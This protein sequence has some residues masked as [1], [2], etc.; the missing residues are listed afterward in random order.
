[1]ENISRRE[2][3][4]YSI[5]GA[6]LMGA[7]TYS[8]KSH[9][10]AFTAAAIATGEKIGWAAKP[11]IDFSVDYI[12]Q[13]LMEY[14]LNVNSH[15]LKALTKATEHVYQF[16]QEL[17]RHDFSRR[18]QTLSAS[19]SYN[20]LSAVALDRGLQFSETIHSLNTNQ[21]LSDG[22]NDLGPIDL[23]ISKFIFD[24]DA[25]ESLLTTQEA[26][27][28]KRFFQRMSVPTT[29]APRT[30]LFAKNKVALEA[31]KLLNHSAI[32]FHMASQF[33]GKH[34]DIAEKIEST[35]LNSEWRDSLNN[36]SADISLLQEVVL[37]KATEVQLEFELLI[38]EQIN[39]VLECLAALDQADK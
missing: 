21:T 14:V 38:H 1:M 37:Q 7:G 22:N 20:N 16:E 4:K 17:D 35:Y 8:S 24:Q 23:T 12:S 28:L 34:I 9:A 32:N 3:F 18:I 36:S 11:F 29:D 5:G 30:K 33:G 6:E 10:F 26:I 15:N 31:R 19:C 25:T 27:E 2:L 13:Y 39:L